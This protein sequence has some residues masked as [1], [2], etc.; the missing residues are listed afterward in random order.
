MGSY[1]EKYITQQ[2]RIQ[3]LLQAAKNEV[4]AEGLNEQDILKAY[5][6]DQM[7]KARAALAEARKKVDLLKNDPTADP[8]ELLKAQEAVLQGDIKVL[9]G[10]IAMAGTGAKGLT[11]Q[12]MLTSGT[13]HDFF[14]EKTGEY[15]EVSKRAG[16]LVEKY[17]ENLREGASQKLVDLDNQ[18]FLDCL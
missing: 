10:R 16:Q 7:E 11:L 2:K 9:Q 5:G 4:S 18:V 12:Q 14:D 17:M 15:V 8:A 3:Q 6:V 1:G 13:S